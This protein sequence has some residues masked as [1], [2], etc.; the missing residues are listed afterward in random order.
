METNKSKTKEMLLEKKNMGTHA[1]NNKYLIT[2]VITI[3]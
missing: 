2:Q 1:L 3:I